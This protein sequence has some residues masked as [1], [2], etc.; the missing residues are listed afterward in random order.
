MHQ[1]IRRRI[2]RSIPDVTQIL[3]HARPLMFFNIQNPTGHY[4]LARGMR[5][6]ERQGFDASALAFRAYP[7]GMGL[8]DSLELQTE[9]KSSVV[10]CFRGWT[11][12]IQP[13]IR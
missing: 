4:R 8:G 13:S 11:C 5:R 6:I 10:S 3:Q 9:D 7:Q 1:R 12:R 2:A